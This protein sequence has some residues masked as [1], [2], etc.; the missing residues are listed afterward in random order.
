[1]N[2]IN[3]QETEPPLTFEFVKHWLLFWVF[4]GLLSHN[5]IAQEALADSAKTLA[6]DS[7]LALRTAQGIVINTPDLHPWCLRTTPTPS[8][9]AIP[10]PDNN[11]TAPFA[12]AFMLL[13]LMA[14]M[15]QVFPRYMD[16]L[17]SFIRPG[18]RTA[19]QDRLPLQTD[20]KAVALFNMLYYVGLGTVLYFALNNYTH[21]GIGQAPWVFWAQVCGALLLYYAL[22]YLFSNWVANTFSQID[23]LERYRF[24]TRVVNQTV[25]LFLLPCIILLIMTRQSNIHPSMIGISLALIL[26]GYAIRTLKSRDWVVRLLNIDG[27]HFLLYLCAFEFLPIVVLFK[28]VKGMA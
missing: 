9:P 15:R 23:T 11:R 18:N 5:G 7:N 4:F 3:T 20:E 19:Q 22:R 1:V 2:E 13:S 14:F 17:T 16:S 28:L 6:I 27:V 26:V 25:A 12:L 21:W 24:M 8:H 10:R